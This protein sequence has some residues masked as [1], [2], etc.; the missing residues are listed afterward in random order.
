MKTILTKEV[1]PKKYIAQCPTCG[2]VLKYDLGDVHGTGI[3]TWHEEFLVCP[4]CQHHLAHSNKSPVKYN[5]NIKNSGILLPEDPIIIP[6]GCKGY[7]LYLNGTEIYAVEMEKI[8][9]A[10][11]P[12]NI[13]GNATD[14]EHIPFMEFSLKAQ[15][16]PLTV[17]TKQEGEVGYVLNPDDPRNYMQVDE[18]YEGFVIPNDEVKAGMDRSTSQY[19][20]RV[21]SSDELLNI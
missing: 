17:Q 3:S 5:I 1:I 6:D 8:A 21:L 11:V 9:P 13:I 2:S 16:P 18:D 19:T 7:N 12:L 4:V 10:G 20:V 15:L 14:I